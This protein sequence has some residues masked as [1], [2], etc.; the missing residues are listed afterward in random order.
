[1]IATLTC[2]RCLQSLPDDAPRGL[3]PKC[4]LTTA[5][6]SDSA[7]TADLG[8]KPDEFAS[9]MTVA[10]VS[11][12]RSRRPATTTERVRYFGDY[13]VEGEIARGGMGVVYRARQLSLNRPVA[14]KMILAGQIAGEA[15]V[16]RFHAEAEAAAG[17]DHPNIVPIYEVGE[18]LGQHY[19]S[20]KL[21]DGGSLSGHVA[22]LTKDPRAAAR[23]MATVARAVHH[24]H[25]RGI[26]HRDLKPANILLDSGGVPHVTDFGLARHVA[27]DSGLTRSGAVTGTPSYMAPEQAGGAKTAITTASDV[28]GLGAILYELLTGRAPFRGESIAE[29]LFQVLDR[30]PVHPR[31]LKP[32]VDRDLE[33]I[34][35]KCLDK[36]PRRRYESAEALAEELERWLACEPILA[37]PV[38]TVERVRKWARRRPAIAA[39][40]AS[41]V[42][43]TTIGLGGIVWQWREAVAAR[44]RA[45]D[46]TLAARIAT[47]TALAAKA[48][49]TDARKAAEKAEQDQA[50]ARRQEAE[51]KRKALA[52]RDAKVA[53]LVRA[54]GL[55][56]A[57]EAS[58]AR[59][60]DPALGLLLGIEG[61]HRAPSH[62]TFAPLY[63]ALA[64][65]RE[66]RTIEV[67]RHDVAPWEDGAVTSVAYRPDGTRL[68]S[69][70]E[71]GPARLWD[72]A[73]GALV[74]ELN[75][76]RLCPV[77]ARFSPDGTRIA[78]TA[79]GYADVMH[80]DGKTYLYT[81]R[82]V[83]LWDAA[84][85]REI[86]RLRGHTSK[87]ISTVFSADG[88][89]ILTASWDGSARLWDCATGKELRSFQPQKPLPLLCAQFS[90]DGR[91]VLTVITNRGEVA[92]YPDEGRQPGTIDPEISQGAEPGGSTG[93]MNFAASTSALAETTVARLWDTVSGNEIAA[94]KKSRPSPFHF[95]H[96]WHPT[97]ATFAPDGRR[98]AITFA[99]KT[100][101]VWA[102]AAS[103]RELI[104]YDGHQGP[105]VAAR[106]C[107]DGEHLISVANA[108]A[109]CHIQRWSIATGKVDDVERFPPARF[110]YFHPSNGSYLLGLENHSAAIGAKQQ[111]AVQPAGASFLDAIVRTGPLLGHTGPVQGADLAPDG[112]HIATAGDNTIRIWK[113]GP[114][115]PIERSLARHDA[116]VTALVYSADGRRLLTAGKDGVVRISDP[117]TGDELRMFGTAK[118]L[119]EIRAAEFS[120]DGRR[121]ITAS[122]VARAKENGE[123][124]NTSSVHVWDAETGADLLALPQHT[125]GALFARL[126]PDGLRLV[127]VTDGG[128]TLTFDGGLVK[129]A[130]VDKDDS[131]EAGVT[132][133]W[134]V[135]TGKRLADLP[136]KATAQCAPS[137]SPDSRRVLVID[138]DAP[139]VRICDCE[140]G[141][142]L[143][144]LKRHKQSIEHA[145]F[146]ND[147]RR[148]ATA[149]Q[150]RTACLW[151]A[152]TGAHLATFQDFGQAPSRV[153]FSPDGALMAVAAGST[154][155]VWE[156]STR[157]LTATI[158]GHEA[159]L[160]TITFSPDGKNLLT[161]AQDR[162]AA[163]WRTIDGRMLS[164]YHGHRAAVSLAVF[165][166]DGHTV[167]T[168][169][170]E[171]SVRVW[172]LD[173]EP[174]FVARLPRG[175]T[176]V[177]RR[178][179][180]LT[181]EAAGAANLPKALP[182]PGESVP[183][184]TK[185]APTAD[186]AVE[187]AAKQKLDAIANRPI[188]P[189]RGS[190]PIRRQLAALMSDFPATAAAIDAARRIT[191][192]PSPL[193][194][195]DPEKIAADQRFRWQPKELVAVA[196]DHHARHWNR[197]E[198][199]NFLA[200]GR[201]ILTGGADNAS[202]LWDAA[203]LT[204]RATLRGTLMAVRR[205]GQGAATLDGA[206][207]RFW[208]LAAD[209]PRESRTID[210]EYHN[211]LAISPDLKTLVRHGR[212]KAVQVLD[213]SGTKPVERGA[214]AG[215][216]TPVT[217]AEFS[218]DGKT[219]VSADDKG[220][221][222]IWDMTGEAP[223][224]RTKIVGLP[225]GYRR[226][227]VSTDGNT[228]VASV[229]DKLVRVWD[230]SNSEPKIRAEITAPDDW[231]SG[232]AVTPDLKTLAVSSGNA[233]RLYDLTA[234]R[235]K[236]LHALRGYHYAPDFLAFSADGTRLATGGSEGALRTW[237]LSG[238]P[239]REEPAVA[240]ADGAALAVALAPDGGSLVTL[241]SQ[242][243]GRMWELA[244]GS[245]VLRAELPGAGPAAAFSADGSRL[246]STA[247]SL[248]VWDAASPAPR[249]SARI[250]GHRGYSF[251]P[252]ILDLARGGRLAATI[253]MTPN[254]RL[255][256][257]SGPSPRASAVI[258][259]IDK[260]RSIM[261]DV[262][263]S[264]DGSLVAVGIGQWGRSLFI[265]RITPD[266]LLPVDAP[267]F[268]CARR[269]SFSPDGKTLA[270][271]DTHEAIR[272]LDL[273]AAVPSERVVLKAQHVVGGDGA[274]TSIAFDTD[275]QR[276]VSTDRSGHVV[277]WNTATGNLLH[278]WQLPG[279]VN[280]AVFSTDGRHIALANGNGTAYV[281]R[282]G[283]MEGR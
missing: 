83:R 153:A 50:S 66:V 81:D 9:D 269:L 174:G 34:C 31:V 204:E 15:E 191:T 244:H 74:V 146:S 98:V 111:L 202:R 185:L 23:L 270:V 232:L 213:L 78:T 170:L 172:P 238:N 222:I 154:A 123:T 70:S 220:N 35:L 278:E 197:I 196:G 158:K 38:G 137:F 176:D 80:T 160:S 246:I 282:I 62:I 5:L 75:D 67:R 119:G 92:A 227:A 105:V 48:R 230:V 135:N 93:H 254:L 56:L 142:A 68:L 175:L 260:H 99:E 36:N 2:P 272:L 40:C 47:K 186:P 65:C 201:L 76:L 257:L 279:L 255:W 148:V 187:A 235:S 267:D 127:T 271:S 139:V 167:A 265:W 24:A 268:D 240:G 236:E 224:A 25:Q 54:D 13:A 17:L 223:R 55:R 261:G 141:K 16:R 273:T 106:F 195:L 192:L 242:G 52:E 45:D 250:D 10:G 277:L 212:T 253:G 159:D 258:D 138:R 194:Q 247:G 87:V 169:D 59:H 121:V 263:L 209:P 43:V 100:A 239:P 57:A 91:Q 173:V 234:E 140:T 249:V 39:M 276:L 32:R 94:F 143:R 155:Y 147:G 156:T 19:F 110:V 82:V 115:Q 6:G 79:R 129:G 125:E 117:S 72:A 132:R 108:P 97:S 188:Q 49:E 107:A 64:D 180:D 3:C 179:Y 171:G 116:T 149:S 22:R 21:I 152:E 283:A 144:T 215:H 168:G 233:V 182:P 225:S 237:D 206:T 124:L 20:M 60:F 71:K 120:T 95:T 264:P 145:V 221:L 183:A 42:V 252:H 190:E 114:S 58:A 61:V 216:D 259:D 151:D 102:T 29:T 199:I 274:L 51:E 53:A 189:D 280:Q 44:V 210:I 77:T 46:R 18:H 86:M 211:P 30:E 1:M 26:L 248:L 231:I 177:E 88:R 69:T 208:D 122:R 131:S 84:T 12:L 184:L 162:T 262:A 281:L 164:L 11:P 133:T 256:D 4:L 73:S 101:S 161:A 37:R 150:D 118:S 228:L 96:V 245:L 7:G 14:L 214:L 200:G 266:G 112:R 243:I 217:A 218:A 163:T 275:G 207:V 193:D 229:K 41:L 181:K 85:G 178:R 104:S 203:T 241:S 205:D 157:K 134:D 113:I 8:S 90:P 251:A 103:A 136:G 166:P 109:E 198:R 89:Q 165:S 226:I 128:M 130:Q 33:T 63:A 126:S 27:S 28:Y 219:L